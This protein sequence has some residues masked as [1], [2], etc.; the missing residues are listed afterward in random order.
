METNW[1]V[2]ERVAAIIAAKQ[3]EMTA[4]AEEEQRKRDAEKATA[5]ANALGIIADK[6]GEASSLLPSWIVQYEATAEYLN[7]RDERNLEWIGDG[8]Q[9]VKTLVFKIPGLSLIEF[10]F[11]ANQWRSSFAGWNDEEP[12]D[13]PKFFFGRDSWWRGS[14][15]YTLIGA[16]EEG[17]EYQRLLELRES[18]LA[19][20]NRKEEEV[21]QPKS[22]SEPSIEEKAEPEPIQMW[23][24]EEIELHVREILSWNDNEMGAAQVRATLLVADQLRRI[25]D[26]L[27]SNNGSEGILCQV[28]DGSF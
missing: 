18:T 4:E 23:T 9:L 15:E 26:V 19:R 6:L 17:K 12:E 20:L 5:V 8:R 11:D 2:P 22:E 21:N 3:A 14:L 25:A 16:Q 24:A 1:K 27:E 28:R 7:Q 13:M 10:D